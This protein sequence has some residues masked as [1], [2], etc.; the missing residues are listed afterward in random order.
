MPGYKYRITVAPITDRQGQPLDIPAL[1]FDIE[2]HDEILGIVERLRG[3]EDLAF[4]PE[5]TAAFA[6]GLKLFSQVLV[7]HRK[8]PVFAPL[9]EP[10]RAFMQLLKKGSGEAG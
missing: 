9:R 2:N 4:G 1:S 10:F 3:R 6:V 5:K 7:E 8:H